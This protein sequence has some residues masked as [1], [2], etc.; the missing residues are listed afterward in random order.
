MEKLRFI[1]IGKDEETARGKSIGVQEQ[2]GEA[3][4]TAEEAIEAKSNRE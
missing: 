4:G 2:E 3:Q 1:N